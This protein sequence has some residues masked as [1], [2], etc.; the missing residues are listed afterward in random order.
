M[1]QQPIRTSIGYSSSSSKNSVE[2][3]KMLH[4]LEQSSLQE[5]LQEPLHSPLQHAKTIFNY[6]MD[7]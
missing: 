3:Q 1:K 6:H 4:E 5:P 2:L 7:T